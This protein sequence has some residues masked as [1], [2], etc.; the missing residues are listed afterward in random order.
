MPEK[1][2]TKAGDRCKLQCGCRVGNGKGLCR[3][4]VE[5]LQ[6]EREALDQLA[7]TCKMPAKK[8]TKAGDRCKLQCGCRAGKGK[9]LC[10]HQVEGLQ[11]ERE[12]LDA[13]WIRK[14]EK[15]KVAGDAIVRRI[16][17]LVRKRAQP[18]LPCEVDLDL[19]TACSVLGTKWDLVR[20]CSLSAGKMGSSKLYWSPSSPNRRSLSP[21][22]SAR[23]R[24][25]SE[26]LRSDSKNDRYRG[27]RNATG[28]V[29]RRINA[30]GKQDFLEALSKIP[31]DLTPEQTE[32]AFNLLDVDKNGWFRISQAEQTLRKAG[33]LP[34]INTSKSSSTTNATKLSQ[35]AIM[36]EMMSVEC[37]RT[38]A[39]SALADQ[40]T[41]RELDLVNSRHKERLINVLTTEEQV[42]FDR[43]TA[44][45]QKSLTK[46]MEQQFASINEL[47]DERVKRLRPQLSASARAMCDA[48]KSSSNK[49]IGGEPKG[50]SPANVSAST[51]P[52]TVSWVRSTCTENVANLTMALMTVTL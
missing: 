10:G 7:T 40:W 48:K 33:Y 38:V 6:K 49:S 11:K 28:E 13:E 39:L 19:I 31:L 27:D 30:I 18:A 9:G 17:E 14:Y 35:E 3:H 46:A 8:L 24:A 1:K 20:R 2:L 50:T 52:K 22:Q 51:G 15:T 12:A 21:P 43:S 36:H 5:G 32:K 47:F 4:Q 42:R 44:A 23:D 34:R 16:R 45:A 37:E 25:W 26:G 29:G 41:A